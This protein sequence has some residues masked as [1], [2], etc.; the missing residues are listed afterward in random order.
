M[1][2][3]E[4]G[5]WK[6]VFIHLIRMLDSLG[7]D[8]KADFNA[9]FFIQLPFI[10]S[11][12]YAWFAARFRALGTF[13]IDTIR[14]FYDDVT[15]MKKLAAR[16]YEDILQARF[17]VFALIIS[18]NFIVSVLSHV[19][20]GSS[21]ITIKTFRSCSLSWR[22]GISLPNCRCTRTQQFQPFK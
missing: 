7:P 9:R 6:S 5:V 14:R 18:A 12:S 17:T 8:I 2:E 20:P 4:L 19:F 10:C 21:R 22:N 13:G 16:D 3:F 1:H 11:C 15:E